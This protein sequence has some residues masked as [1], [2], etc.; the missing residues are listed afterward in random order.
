MVS[1]VFGE[2]A[3]QSNA[4]PKPLFLP[5]LVEGGCEYSLDSSCRGLDLNV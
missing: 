1:S 4:G 5:L 2:S 3:H